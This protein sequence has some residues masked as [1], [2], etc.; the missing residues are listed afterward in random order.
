MGP[1]ASRIA[2]AD[3]HAHLPHAPVRESDS[4]LAMG[5]IERISSVPH[6]RPRRP[7]VVP[8]KSMYSMSFDFMF[9]FPIIP[10]CLC[11]QLLLFIPPC[12]Q[13]L[14]T[15]TRTHVQRDAY[16]AALQMSINSGLIDAPPTRNPSMSASLAVSPAYQIAQHKTDEIRSALYSRLGGKKEKKEK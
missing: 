2:C 5:M 15:L 11:V 13:R 8:E 14:V 6:K 10:Q 1:H 3:A 9:I 12:R 7:I 4:Q 16:S